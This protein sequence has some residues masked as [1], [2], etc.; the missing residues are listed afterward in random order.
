MADINYTPHSTRQMQK[1]GI[2]PIP[3]GLLGYASKQRAPHGAFFY[4]FTRKSLDQAIRDGYLS[5]QEGE[6]IVNTHYVVK[7]SILALT[8][9]TAYKQE[10]GIKKIR[11]LRR[12]KWKRMT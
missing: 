10:G 7:A 5:P 2:R 8:I 9:V 1:R 3:P 6:K 12:A 11:E 4:W